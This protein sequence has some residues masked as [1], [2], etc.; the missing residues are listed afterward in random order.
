MLEK[1]SLDD[2]VFMTMVAYLMLIPVIYLA[3]ILFLYAK[4]R[5]RGRVV[6]NRLDYESMI[7]HVTF[8]PFYGVY[9]LFRGAFR[10]LTNLN[11]FIYLKINNLDSNE[12]SKDC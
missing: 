3:S 6:I 7:V 1:T 9:I 10:V 11:N 2:I 4:C 12:L 5:L 8:W